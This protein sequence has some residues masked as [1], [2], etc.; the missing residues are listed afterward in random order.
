[1][2]ERNVYAAKNLMRV[3]AALV[4][5]GVVASGALS[6]VLLGLLDECN[7]GA[8]GKLRQPQDVDLV[9]ETILA[10][11]PIAVSI[12]SFLTLV[13]YSAPACKGSKPSTMAPYWRP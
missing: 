7:N 13:I 8:G 4:D 11:L 1:V 6:A 3:L 12:I 9:L 5:Y 10:A 2:V